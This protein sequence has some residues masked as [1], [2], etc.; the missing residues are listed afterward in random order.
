ML[1][2]PAVWQHLYAMS[3]VLLH[4]LSVALLMSCRCVFVI[5]RVPTGS[6]VE[7]VFSFSPSYCSIFLIRLIIILLGRLNCFPPSCTYF[8][9]F[10]HFFLLRLF[11]YPHSIHLPPFFLLSLMSFSRLLLILIILR[12]SSY[13]LLSSTSLTF[14]VVSTYNAPIIPHACL[15]TSHSHLSSCLF[16][17]SSSFILLFIVFL[18]ILFFCHSHFCISSLLVSLCHCDS[19][20]H[21]PNFRDRSP[22]VSHRYNLMLSF[23]KTT[24][25]AVCCVL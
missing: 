25:T 5:L 19:V 4:V 18:F 20:I 9:Y 11:R 10:C 8:L 16:S 12:F 24:G 22:A 17:F 14:P 2:Q 3:K 1:K 21:E 7:I 13:F 23:R 15:S 6:S